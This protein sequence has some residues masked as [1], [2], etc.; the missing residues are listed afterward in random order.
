MPESLQQVVELVISLVI[1]VFSVCFHEAAHGWAAFKLG[2][3][4]AYRQGRVTL[5]PVA[6]IDPIQT[7]LMPLFFYVATAGA[8]I[9]GGAKPVPLNPFLFKN[10]N[11][12]LMIT[13]LAG[14]VSNLLLAAVAGLLYLPFGW[15]ILR[16][17]FLDFFFIQVVWINVL[18]LTFNLIPIPPLDGSRV[19]RYFLPHET[20]EK[21]D[22]LEP[23]GLAILLLVL[24]VTPL[25]QI[26]HPFRVFVVKSLL[27]FREAGR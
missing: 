22:R 12:G 4:T 3:P 11:K 5:N 24:Y 26:I 27:I 1:L 9:F 14:P 8:V 23:F 10:V 15:L 13:G 7:I 17:R 18:L 25:M 19:V 16:D 6:H 2:D 21:Y 20:R